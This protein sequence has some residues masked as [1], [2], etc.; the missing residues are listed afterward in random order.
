MQPR[1]RTRPV[2]AEQI[3]LPDFLLTGIVRSPGQTS[4][5]EFCS[6]NTSYVSHEV[7]QHISSVFLS[8]PYF[9][10]CTCL[11]RV[12]LPSATKQAFRIVRPVDDNQTTFPELICL[13][14]GSAV[15]QPVFLQRTHPVLVNDLAHIMQVH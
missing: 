8:T 3:L 12:V 1:R 2:P 7:S 4:Q 13:F 6:K 15:N 11:I 5:T 10:P 14:P 9:H